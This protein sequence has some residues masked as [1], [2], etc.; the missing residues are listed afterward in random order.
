MMLKFDSTLLRMMLLTLSL[1]VLVSPVSVKAQDEA[2]A[3]PEAAGDNGP[4]T[5]IN[6]QPAFVANY[7]GKGRLRFLRAEVSL[8][9]E[10]GGEQAVMHH[11]PYIRHKLI[12]ILSR[13]TDETVTTMEGK[14]ML[15]QEALE[16]VR[17]VL[18]AEEGEHA[19]RDLLFSSFII[20]R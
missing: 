4:T 13:Q 17:S 9:V 16:A 15:R 20:Q 6:L 8:R 7:G 19:L 1:L 2:P 10:Q 11:M 12:M 5:Y 14:E 18:M 3:A